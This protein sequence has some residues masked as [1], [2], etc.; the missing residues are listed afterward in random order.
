MR[1]LN[2]PELVATT[3][4][5]FVAKAVELTQNADMRAEL[6]A[7]IEERRGGLFGDIAPVRALE[8]RLMEASERAR[9]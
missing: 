9:V 2:L 1:Q 3:T 7:K 6:K 4:D 5:E 8:C